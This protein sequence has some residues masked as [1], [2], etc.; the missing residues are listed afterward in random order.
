MRRNLTYDPALAQTTHSTIPSP[1][2]H[3]TG[4]LRTFSAWTQRHRQLLD[5]VKAIIL[6]GFCTILEADTTD[7]ALLIPQTSQSLAVWS[8]IYIVP[9]SVR[10]TH[11]DAG[12]ISFVVI[13]ALQLIFG[14][15]V[16]VANLSAVIMLYS[17]IVYGAP[18]RSRRYI[19]IALA[20]G[21]F[22]AF[23]N[24][25]SRHI[26]PLFALN[27]LASVSPFSMN[28]LA[29]DI[30]GYLIPI[31]TVLLSCAAMGY[32]RRARLH[33][34]NL[35]RERNRALEESQ[36]EELHIAT[37]A[38]RSRI[39]R[40]MHDVVAHTLSI[41][42]VQADGGRYAG[43][44]NPEVGLSTMRTIRDETGS[45]LGSMNSL[46]GTLGEDENLKR[47]KQR[48]L[49]P[50][51]SSLDALLHEAQAAS[52]SSIVIER[53]LHG[54]VR[55]AELAPELSEALFRTVQEALSNIRKYAGS[56]V[57]VD[58][59]EWW[60]PD[61]VTLTI[62]DDGKGAQASQDGHRPG[63]GL[64]GMN[65]RITSLG[66]TVH[67]G[68]RR[69]ES[70]TEHGFTV[71]VSIPLPHD[72][73]DRNKTTAGRRSRSR[74]NFIERSS[75]WTQSHF[76][77]IDLV[78]AIALALF[79]SLNEFFYPSYEGL[80]VALQV[81][82]A[83]AFALPL[84]MR[85]TRPQLSAALIAGLL[86]ISLLASPDLPG[87]GSIIALIALYSVLVYGPHKAQ[88]W[89]YPTALCIIGLAVT[90]GWRNLTTSN[91]QYNSM[92]PDEAA[93]AGIR[94]TSQQEIIATCVGIAVVVTMTVLGIIF[95]A[96]WKRASGSDIVLLRSRE[97]ALIQQR[98]RQTALA[99]NLERARISEQI[100]QEV[101]QTLG[102][103]LRTTDSWIPIVEK[104][105]KNT[106]QTTPKAGT[107]TEPHDTPQ[108]S[109]SE[110]ATIQKAFA[111][112]AEI[113]RLALK[114]MRELLGILRQNETDQEAHRPQLSP[115][116]AVDQS[117]H[118]H[119]GETAQQ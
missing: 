89:V 40:D 12:A 84:A 91:Q 18:K 80:S 115:I 95:F 106:Q 118:S 90:N 107:A 58:I 9:L 8:L 101:T 19:F 15:T 54:T 57:H 86:I 55:R 26:S 46:L 5:I 79:L 94:Y 34:L 16:V 29:S 43:A 110:S 36:K 111:D 82:E 72:H 76:A 1:N 65:E 56:R 25:I 68:P 24:A 2:R 77:L 67:A 44:N 33:Q 108:I 37:L 10:R 59:D 102:N 113:G 47:Q 73:S 7:S 22:V 60:S 112:I 31:E 117:T 62:A 14:P 4:R 23:I 48:A 53:T 87:N 42:I 85:R 83:I 114:Q 81:I 50:R 97:E 71:T 99:A 74:A 98:D 6:I 93:A 32:W 100:Q 52:G 92:T 28:E 78:L 104:I 21:F 75:T 13:A 20:M 96:L 3:R 105:Q 49:P 27:T 116:M 35:L 66:G 61:S 11:A 109:A 17:A 45:A 41:I 63:Y 88:R 64:I 70:E 51:Y 38:E 30:A 119:E 69:N 103:V 39:A